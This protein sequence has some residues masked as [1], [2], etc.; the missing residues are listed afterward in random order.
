LLVIVPAVAVN[1]AV[2][3]PAPTV[4]EA[5]TVNDAT[6]SDSATVA[7]PAF[8]TVTVHV[9][10][11]PELRDAGAQLSALRVGGGGGATVTITP[12]P[13][14][15]SGPPPALT[16]NVSIALIAVLATPDAIL[17]LTTATT[18]SWITLVFKPISRQT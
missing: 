18:P 11:P 4:T 12:T 8:D 15:G 2:V 13:F 1:V 10:D 5:G 7:P 14:M 3:L 17:T 6:L 9:D 16:P